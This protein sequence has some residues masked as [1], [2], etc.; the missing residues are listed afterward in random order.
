MPQLPHKENGDDD[1]RISLTGLLQGL[2]EF[3]RMHLNYTW[4]TVLFQSL[5]LFF[6]QQRN[7]FIDHVVRIFGLHLAQRH[8]LDTISTLVLCSLGNDSTI[9]TEIQEESSSSLVTVVYKV[10]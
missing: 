5:L 8:Y 7:F 6:K 4:Y 1:K 3:L 10:T 9:G 2:H